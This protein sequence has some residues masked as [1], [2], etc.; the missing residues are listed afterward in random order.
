MQPPV[1]SSYIGQEVSQVII[2][3]RLTADS[4]LHPDQKYVY[5]VLRIWGLYANMA[6]V[7]KEQN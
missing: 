2:L 6:Q 5:T 4:S 7:V 3:I 1:Y